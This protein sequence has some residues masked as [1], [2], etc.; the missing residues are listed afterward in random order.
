MKMTE[1]RRIILNIA[2][3]YL[4]SFYT[5]ALG[6][7][8]ARWLLM[9]LGEVDYGL[10]GLVGG[11]VAFVTLI[12]R[13]F[14]NAVGRF[15]AV[16][17][18]KGR[19]KGMAGESLLECRRWFT[20]A[21]SIH[22]VVPLLLVAVGWPVGEYA[23]SHWLVIPADRIASCVWVWRLACIS[24]FVG[25]VNVPFRAMY[26][27]KQEIA[28]L[29]FLSIASA[30]LNALL[31]YYMVSHPGDWLARY[32][33]WHCLIVILPMVVI[34][35]R[36]I[37]VYPECRLRRDCL[38]NAADLRRLA[39]FAGWNAF[40]MAGTVIKSKGF[41]VVVNAAFGPVA[42]A[43][44]SVAT[45]LAA[46]ANTFASSIVSSFT[47]AIATSYGA[48]REDGVATL[49]L[50][51]GKMSGLVVALVSVPLFLEVDE[52]MRL[53]LKNPPDNSAYLCSCVLVAFFLDK[54]SVGQRSAI[55]ASGKI[56]LARFLNGLIN[57]LAVPAACALVFSGFGIRSIGWVIIGAT[58]LIV[59]TRVVIAE[60]V[61]G[62]EA[63]R[64]I[65]VTA[66]PL[67]A[68][69]AIG[70]ALGLMPRLFALD[71]V[72]RLLVT[73]GASEAAMLPFAWFVVISRRERAYVVEKSAKVF[74]KL[75][76]RRP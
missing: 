61:A 76:G 26:T 74:R 46:K 28:E 58:L 17:I 66:L 6:L 1:N 73:I 70:L 12:N 54:F 49:V 68:M 20:S 40:S 72:S 36:A 71:S 3:T 65:M 75:V 15:Y 48:G 4:R 69:V 45:R 30:T 18:G 67:L 55:A 51:V 47:P 39:A 32:A 64:W 41:M 43:A 14:A 34:C 23:T 24:A 57:I 9:S 62:I 25:M 27:A 63:R 19:R 60:R 7:V 37:A 22:T 53:W 29:T 11:L 44:M 38:W 2:A 31:L 10:F 13:I 52:V 42:N 16:A 59:S 8:T 5:L 33:F 56:A 21:V 35:V 50:L